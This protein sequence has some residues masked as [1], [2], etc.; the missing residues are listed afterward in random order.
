ML[1]R[2]DSPSARREPR[3]AIALAVATLSLAVGVAR[4]TTAGERAD[5]A[6][7]FGR[8]ILPILSNTCF[9]CH[10][11]DENKREAD[12]R[13]DRRDDAFA[14][15]G[16]YFAI[17]PGNSADSELYYRI[18]DPDDPM[19]PAD[20]DKHL[21]ADEIELLRRW[22]DEG[23]EWTEHWAYVAPTRAEPPAVNDGAWPRGAIDRF[24]LARLEAQGLAPEP[25]ADPATLLRRVSLDLTGLPPTVAELDAFLADEAPDAYERAVD[26]LLASPRYGEHMARSWLD[27]ARYG[28]THGL[29]LD[30]ERGIW[31]YRDWVIDAFNANLPFDRF[32]V[33][34]LA[35]DLLPDPTLAQRVA[36]GFNRCNPTTS[37]TGVIDE[38]YYVK[39]AVDRVD[40]VATTW[41]GMTMGCAQCHDHKFD[42]ISQREY[43]EFFAF[44]G[45]LAGAARDG[46][47]PYP[48]P[49]VELPSPEQAA[50]RD[51][52]RARI[53]ARERALKIDDAELDRAQLAWEQSARTTHAARFAP[54]DATPV[55]LGAGSYELTGAVDRAPVAVRIDITPLAPEI[56]AAGEFLVDEVEAEWRAADGA[57]TPLA[58]AD[59]RA[60]DTRFKLDVRE[61]IDGNR[62]TGW[63][64]DDPGE[65]HVL[66]LLVEAGADA[67]GAGELRLRIHTRMR[68]GVDAPSAM[69][70]MR[71]AT[72]AA[73]QLAPL[74]AGAW[75][76]LGPLAPA[77]ELELAAGAPRLTERVGDVEWVEHAH[78]PEARFAKQNGEHSATYS[79]RALTS[80]G[81]R[82]V[83]FTLG[84]FRSRVPPT[85][86]A[87]S[88]RVWLNGELVLEHRV[89]HE[90]PLEE[91]A[92]ELALRDG[93]NHLVVR[94]TEDFGGYAFRIGEDG[95]SLGGLPVSVARELQNAERTASAGAALRRHYRARVAPQAPASDRLR[96]LEYALR[97]VEATIPRSLVIEERDT[98]AHTYVLKRGQYDLKGEEVLPGTPSRLP[99]LD[100]PAE[101]RAN[102]L[103]LARWLVDPAHPLTARVAVNR[104]WQELFGAGIVRTTE[105]FGIQGA[106]P[107]HPELLDWLALDFIEHGWDVKRLV[108]ELV[109]S[110]TYR[111]SSTVT[112]DKRVADPRNRWLG[113]AP[114]YRLD[115]ERIRDSALAIGGL[116]VEHIGGP[117]VRPYQPDGLWEP[118][119]YTGSNT[120]KFERDDGDAHYR[121]SLYT[122]WKRTSPPPTMTLFDA[123]TRESCKL[124]RERTNTPLQ[125][126][127]L[128]NDEQFVEAAR[129]LATRI[130]SAELASDRER[131]RFGLRS[132]VAREPDAEDVRPLLELLEDARAHYANDPDAAAALLAVG[133][134]PVAGEFDAA[135]LAAWTVV[136]NL[137]LNLDEG[138]TKE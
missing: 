61:A 68:P 4:G 62:A 74:A 99:D 81:A 50:A 122:F 104:I 41:L 75:W 83:P 25:E 19:P 42:P 15:L 93:E 69:E 40:T 48:E 49:S 17:V 47:A 135:E 108:R 80:D 107:T 36:T 24:V 90:V 55:D 91:R 43:F 22:I 115:A 131:V 130:L 109:T 54:F 78:W 7:D 28:D 105:D 106:R 18:T 94:A 121:R 84:T 66:Y 114:R 46:N 92:F 10:G 60:D 138:V 33:E 82:V 71:V 45:N 26:R 96:A 133:A 12:L 37:E 110:A 137:L 100:A 119:A 116:L 125:A 88:V 13:F 1:Q 9:E 129:G 87:D 59:A 97:E 8:D 2:P 79:Y 53:A 120:G 118:L 14:D 95:R 76:T 72:S 85:A 27:A 134:S 111:Q 117:S 77:T 16:G 21:T 101:R 35:G 20:F 128:L 58:F 98:P 56:D 5:D 132:A 136:A 63:I 38:E 124:R 44:F 34:Q 52:L 112:S 29:S 73:A 31:P 30:N 123:P 39:Y 11:P 86:T 51:D 6:I 67:T 70:R 127:A 3:A 32:T 126:L 89:G 102:R 23:A 64:A 113:R 103:D 65:P 57:F